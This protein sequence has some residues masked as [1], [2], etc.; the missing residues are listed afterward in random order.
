M[1]VYIELSR[2]NLITCV[3]SLSNV[4]SF[5]DGL[6]ELI[7]RKSAEERPYVVRTVI[8]HHRCFHMMLAPLHSTDMLVY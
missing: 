8:M 7:Q 5:S 3:A 1:Y 6:K 2:F 4:S